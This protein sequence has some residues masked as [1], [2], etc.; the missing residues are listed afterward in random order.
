LPL[1]S[2]TCLRLAMSFCPDWADHIPVGINFLLAGVLP[3]NND[4]D[5]WTPCL[6]G[7]PNPLHFAVRDALGGPPWGKFKYDMLPPLRGNRWRTAAP[8][9]TVTSGAA[10]S[11]FVMKGLTR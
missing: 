9:G 2:Y 3:K 5:A 8:S 1:P 10:G 7:D 4:G 11:G 6:C